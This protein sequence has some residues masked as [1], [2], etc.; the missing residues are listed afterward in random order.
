MP[1][2]R[3]F[4]QIPKKTAPAHWISSWLASWRP[5]DCLSGDEWEQ[6]AGCTPARHAEILEESEEVMEKVM[7]APRALPR[8]L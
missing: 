4:R 7:R 3:P 8:M 5:S 6:F 2:V 1:P